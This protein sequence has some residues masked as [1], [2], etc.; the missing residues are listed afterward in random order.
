MLRNYDENIKSRL[1]SGDHLV[2]NKIGYDTFIHYIHE[3]QSA[4]GE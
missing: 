2:K 1:S 3:T 4:V